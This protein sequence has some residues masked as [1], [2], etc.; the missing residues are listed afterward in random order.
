MIG[1]QGIEQI[2]PELSTHDIALAALQTD[3]GDPSARTNLQTLIAMMGNPD[4]AG[5]SIYDN[6]GDFVGLVN[7]ASLLALL[8]IPDVS[9]KSLYTVLVTDLLSH[10]THGLA[11]LRTDIAAIPTTMVGTDNA[12]TEAKQD[13]IDTVVDGIQTDLS[14]VTDGLGALKALLDTIT[15][16]LTTEIADILTDTGTTLPALLATIQTD[17]DNPSQYKADLSTL[18]TRLSAVRAGYLDQ[19]DFALQEAIAAIPTTMRGTDSAALAVDLG[20]LATGAAVGA[21]TTADEVMA[22]VKQLVTNSRRVVHR[23]VFWSEIDDLITIDATAGDETLPP[24]TVAE[25]PS[26]A[27]ILRV[28]V[29]LSI[30]SFEDTSG[31]ENKVVLAGTEHVQIDKT[32]GTYI[33]GI[34][35]LAGMWL[36]GA[37]AVRGGLVMIGNIDVASEVDANDTYELKIEGADVTAASLLLRDVQTGLIVY[38][39][40]E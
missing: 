35:M 36:T 13:I 11:Q 21:V 27:V 29:I 38:F 31:S 17:L 37:N 4:A 1:K 16:Y 15:G 32:G 20:A 14:N 12:A 9:G 40:L 22:Y 7:F 5:K 6:L 23:M 3:L 39:T 28:N 10:G 2:R 24:V 8:G 26:G 18:E 25:I 33:D 19:L 30:G 34:K